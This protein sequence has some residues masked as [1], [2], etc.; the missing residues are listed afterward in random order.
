MEKL[1]QYVWQYRLW[2]PQQMRTVDGRTVHVIDQGRLNTDAGPDFFNAKVRIGDRTWVGNIEIH[3]RASDWHRHHHDTDPAYHSVI[4]HVVDRNDDIIHRPNGEPIPQMQMPCSPRLNDHF[5]SLVSTADLDLPC[6]ATAASLPPLLITDWLSALLY[7]RLYHRCER[8][9][10]FRA[11]SRG[12]T[13]EAIYILLARALGFGTNADPFERLARSLPLRT[14]ARHADNPLSVEA[15][16]FGQSGLLA[17]ELPAYGV[18]LQ[19]E[20]QFLASKFSL[21]PLQS[22]GWKMARMRPANFPHRRIALLATIISHHNDIRSKI[23][24]IDTIETARHLFDI[25]LSGYWAHHYHFT[26]T[27]HDTPLSSLSRSSIDLMVINVV[28]PVLFDHGYRTGDTRYT[29]RAISL[30]EQLPPEHNRLVDIFTRAGIRARDASVSQALLELRR[31]YC[32]Q[33]KCLYCRIGHRH[34]SDKASR[35]SSSS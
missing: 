24:D 20:Y 2:P 5:T 10:S 18:Q 21:T 7:Q 34:L 3:V 23:L 8:L 17:G 25:P 15:M 35:L 27:T 26:D 22:P 11:L 1:M 9:D 6:S 13:A 4:L 30:L 32:H 19:R 29:E 16:L 31:E 12:D 28:V 33:R 14:L